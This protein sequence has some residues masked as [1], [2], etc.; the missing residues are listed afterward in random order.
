MAE[1]DYGTL[2]FDEAIRFFLDKA[3]IPT[4]RW[5][6]IWKEAHDCGFMVAGAM[7][8][9]LLADLKAAVAKARMQGTTL[10]QFVQDFEAIVAQHGWTGWTGEGSQAGRAWRANVIYETNL[11]TS[12]Q[13]GRWAQV[14]R[15]K[16]RRPYLIYRHS[17]AS[18]HPR[19]LHL[20]WDG[21]VVEVG[22]DWVKS[23]WPPNGWGCKCRMFSLSERDLRQ[24]GKLGPDTPPDDGTYEWAD[25]VTG[26]VHTV[27]NGIDAGWDYA[28]GA[29][30]TDLLKKDL[31][32]KAA[33]FPDEI[34]KPLKADLDR[35]GMPD[36][37][38][39]LSVVESE[40][41]LNAVEQTVVLNADGKVLLRKSGDA[42]SVGF[43]PDELPLLADATVTHNHPVVSS[44]SPKDLQLLIN[45]DLLE[46][47][48]VDEK[49]LY[50]LERVVDSLSPSDK[51]ALLQHID[52]L[53]A[54]GWSDALAKLMRGEITEAE[55]RE[56]LYHWIWSGMDSNLL[57]YHRQSR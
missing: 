29:S 22:S 47:R 26:E 46:L 16:A 55:L 14:Q 4:E 10:K 25:K 52:D 7:K 38:S 50:T 21:L 19:P 13:A 53:E 9:E 30:R 8:A 2:P 23:H 37:L 27:P 51:T 56:N 39:I 45:H 42:N 11:R 18:V 15:V 54:A 24:M 57:I 36:L 33:K 34:G 35:L 5:T 31:E 48:A 43:T 40:I 49:F 20:S 1:V 41:V 12:Y 28:P 3:L 44:F 32:R 17:D 6:D